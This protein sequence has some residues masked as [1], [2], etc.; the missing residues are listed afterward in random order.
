MSYKI[1]CQTYAIRT[2]TAN[3]SDHGD[4]GTGPARGIESVMLVVQEFRWA[5]SG[6]NGQPFGRQH[7]DKCKYSQWAGPGGSRICRRSWNV[8]CK[9]ANRISEL[10]TVADHTEIFWLSDR[11]SGP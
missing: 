11:L 10:N 3:D 8:L 2:L 1:L 5:L 4:D 6:Q 7:T 9:F